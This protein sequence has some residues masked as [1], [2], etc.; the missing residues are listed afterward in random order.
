M[1]VRSLG[2][3]VRILVVAVVSEIT[4]VKRVST[5]GASLQPVFDFSVSAVVGIYSG[6]IWVGTS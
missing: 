4:D 3:S 6:A 5:T 2:N 1:S